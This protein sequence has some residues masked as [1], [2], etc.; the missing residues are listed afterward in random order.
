MGCMRNTY[1]LLVRKSEGKNHMENLSINGRIIYKTRSWKNRMGMCGLASS[2]SGEQPVASSCGN[3]MN[4][5]LHE[6]WGT[7]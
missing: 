1:K 4:L 3:S 2:G 6:R 7:S 5:W